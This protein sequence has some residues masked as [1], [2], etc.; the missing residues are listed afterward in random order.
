MLFLRMLITRR[1]T[2][3]TAIPAIPK[4]SPVAGLS[5]AFFAEATAAVVFTVIVADVVEVAVTTGSLN[6]F[7]AFI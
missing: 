2:A 5:E 6:V 3:G 4:L 1:I 7:F